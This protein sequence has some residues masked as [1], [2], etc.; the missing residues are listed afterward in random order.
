LKI[1][2]SVYQTCLF[3]LVNQAP[4]GMRSFLES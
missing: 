2:I 4:A 1:A 3:W